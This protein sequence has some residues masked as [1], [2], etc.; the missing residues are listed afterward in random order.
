M[1]GHQTELKYGVKVLT[2]L[3]WPCIGIHDEPC[4]AKKRT[5][6]FVKGRG[7]GGLPDQLNNFINHYIMNVMQKSTSC[8]C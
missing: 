4:K 2:G 1:K 8:N 3:I 5:L 6:G 7:K